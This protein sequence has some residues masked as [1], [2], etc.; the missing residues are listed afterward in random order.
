MVN[1]PVHLDI[2]NIAEKSRNEH[3]A[4]LENIESGR[5]L[6]SIQIEIFSS[7]NELRNMLNII[8][9]EEKENSK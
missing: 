5:A 9:I 6:V 8:P 3:K 4:D 7:L 2:D 1:N